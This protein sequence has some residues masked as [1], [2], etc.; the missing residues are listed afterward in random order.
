MKTKGVWARCP[1]TKIFGELLMLAG[2][3]GIV[4]H[5][6]WWTGDMIDWLNL[7]IY[8]ECEDL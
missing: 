1:R 5:N 2:R 3:W 8:L 6:S 7:E 4:M